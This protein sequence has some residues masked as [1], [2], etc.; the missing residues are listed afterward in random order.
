MILK[1]RRFALGGP[2]RV[3]P[4]PEPLDSVAGVCLSTFAPPHFNLAISGALPW[5]FRTPLPSR[6]GWWA[7]YEPNTMARRLTPSN[8]PANLS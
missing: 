3:E 7:D 8:F 6:D 4:Y 2:I 5:W 1:W